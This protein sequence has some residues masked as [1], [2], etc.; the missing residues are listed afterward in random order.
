MF[1]CATQPPTPRVVLCRRWKHDELL[2]LLLLLHLLLLLLLPLMILEHHDCL[3][4]CRCVAACRGHGDSVGVPGLPR[5]GS[6]SGLSV[7][8]QPKWR[9]FMVCSRDP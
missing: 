2:P 8:V 4:D 6:R 1:V 7:C 3:Y 5:P 9:G